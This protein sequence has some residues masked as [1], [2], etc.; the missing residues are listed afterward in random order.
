ME[1]PDVLKLDGELRECKLCGY[2][3]SVKNYKHEQTQEHLRRQALEE[4]DSEIRKLKEIPADSSVLEDCLNRINVILLKKMPNSNVLLFHL[5]TW[6]ETRSVG[7]DEFRKKGFPDESRAKFE[8]ILG[9]LANYP[10]LQ[11]AIKLLK[12]DVRTHFLTASLEKSQA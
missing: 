6:K 11:T 7:P 3:V 9:E 10:A 1:N 12:P 8:N 5:K 4:L 2:S